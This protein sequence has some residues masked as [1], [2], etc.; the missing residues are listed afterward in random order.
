VPSR[1]PDI[2]LPS[3]RFFPRIFR[4]IGRAR[5]KWNDQKIPTK[6]ETPGISENSRLDLD[7]RSPRLPASPGET[8]FLTASILS[9]ASSRGRSS[10]TPA[11]SGNGYAKERGSSARNNDYAIASA[12]RTFLVSGKLDNE[13]TRG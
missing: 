4:S 13:G 9:R 6:M 2:D 8:K 12:A 1:N 7:S 3:H 11:K 10:P 5:W